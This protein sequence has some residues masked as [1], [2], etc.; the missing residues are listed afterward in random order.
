MDSPLCGLVYLIMVTIRSLHVNNISEILL[1]I[2]LII[3]K[4]ELID[5]ER[6]ENIDYIK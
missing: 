5:I 3:I 4:R 1:A 6:L 2:K